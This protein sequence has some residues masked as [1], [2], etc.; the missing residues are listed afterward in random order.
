MALAFVL[1]CGETDTPK[2]EDD[3]VVVRPSPLP[4]ALEHAGQ[5][6]SATDMPTRILLVEDDWAVRAT[7]REV[8]ET[9]GYSVTEA[10][11]AEDG[12][13][14]LRD[15]EFDVLILDLF[16]PGHDGLW[17][18]DQ[19]DPPP[20]VVIVFSAFEYVS[21]ARVK[22]QGGSKIARLLKKPA[23]PSLLLE[24]VVSAIDEWRAGSH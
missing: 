5:S 12:L 4:S 21:Q 8:L 19:I 17:L 16:M 11:D 9:R 24:N 15:Q 14:L 10:P 18:L 23:S 6:A 20:P 7:T 2:S 13:Q 1:E 22:A 3:G